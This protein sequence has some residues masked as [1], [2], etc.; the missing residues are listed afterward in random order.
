MKLAKMLTRVSDMDSRHL[1]LMLAHPG[2]TSLKFIASCCIKGL[3]GII[4]LPEIGL[5]IFGGESPKIL[6]QGAGH[7]TGTGLP[8]IATHNSYRVCVL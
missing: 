4:N 1:L 6:G 3:R 7:E 5:H 2:P 8:I